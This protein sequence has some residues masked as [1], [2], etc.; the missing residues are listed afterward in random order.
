MGIINLEEAQTSMM[1]MDKEGFELYKIRLA[2][3]KLPEAEDEIVV[4]PGMLKELGQQ[5]EIGDII[6]VPC[7][8]YQNGELDY[9]REREFRI[10]GFL[11]ETEQNQEQKVYTA[12]ISEAFLRNKIPE[13]QILYRFLFRVN[14]TQ[15]ETT[16]EIEEKIHQIAEQ[17]EIPE[18]DI[19]I[20]E[21]YL[22]A[23]YVD[24]AVLPVIIMI[25]VIIMLAGTITVYSIYYVS[26][27]QRVQ[28]FG[29]LKAIGATK[30]QVKQIILR[31]G[32][33][34]AVFAIPAGL[35]TGTAVSRLVLREFFKFAESDVEFVNVAEQIFQNGEINLYYWWA[36]LLAIVVTLCTVYLSLMKPMRSAAKISEVESMRYQDTGPK[37]KSRKKGYRYLT[38][39]RLTRRNL[40]GNKKKSAATILAMAVT[41]VFLMVVATVLSCANPTES[42]DGSVLGQY[43]ISPIVEENN[44]EHP[45]RKWSKIQ[46][47]NPLNEELKQQIENLEGVESVVA[48]TAV[49]VSGKEFDE[50]D[51]NYIHGIPE[52]FAEDIEKGLI[53]GKVTYEELKSGDKVV[54]DK[55]LLNW[56]PKFSVGDHLN[57]TVFDGNRTYDKKVEIAAIGDYSYGMVNFDCL[58]MSKEAADRLCENNSTGYYHIFADKDYDPELEKSLQSLLDASG[59]L[60]MRTWKEE[61]E[62]WDT[63]LTMTRGACYAFLVI[64][65]VIS[66]MN[67]IN[68]MINSVYVR[69]KELGMMQAIGMSDRQLMQMLQ[70]EGLFYTLGTL[71]IS[72]G[73]GSLAGYPVF[74]YAKSHGM[75]GI[76]NYHYPIT[77][78]VT[79]AVV[80]LLIQVLLAAGLAKSVKKD[81][82]IERIR[83]SE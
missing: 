24:P 60:Q 39:G 1:Y 71:I 43:E 76:T 15:K 33:F 56:Y 83:F 63:A 11:E 53:E 35:V 37:K 21:D 51:Y 9:S 78:S 67:L 50:G 58:I 38:I 26:M 23:N 3:G 31:E 7:Q 20:N 81:S 14:S 62:N 82:L 47:N 2:E 74:L 29:R 17:F 66:V 57:L 28:E 19:N 13:D 70:L 4:S 16:D 59:R 40:A 25:M 79:I 65:A 12:F 75:F 49:R 41:G 45:E 52:T 55:T 27:N 30:K 64:L 10:S 8:I 68:T 6:H 34:V 72:V 32:L 46:M 44:K 48:F 69:K 42:A 5:G 18:N 36:Y 22:G 54:L 80:L 73:L 77:A 61:Y